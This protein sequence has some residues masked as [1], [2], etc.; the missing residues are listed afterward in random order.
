MKKY[1]NLDKN[2]KIISIIR[3]NDPTLST[4]CL[5]E[6]SDKDYKKVASGKNIEKY[7]VKGGK[8][9][10]KPRIKNIKVK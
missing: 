9:K 7:D 1:L 3:S 10:L 5:F 6:V 8:V 4:E 2:G